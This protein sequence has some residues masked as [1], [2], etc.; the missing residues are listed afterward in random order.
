M[1]S[2]AKRRT[3]APPTITRGLRL[4]R[5]RASCQMVRAAA[6]WS[7]A[8]AADGEGSSSRRTAGLGRDVS[9]LRVADAG[10]D[11]RVQDVDDQVG[12]SNQDR[13]EDHSAQHERIVA[14]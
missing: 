10:V 6:S 14:G 3:L 12:E 8:R 11:H 1:A 13:V 4:I 5:A 2:R 7:A 9:M